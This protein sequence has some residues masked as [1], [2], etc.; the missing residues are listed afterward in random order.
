M[1]PVRKLLSTCVPDHLQT[2]SRVRVQAQSIRYKYRIRNTQRQL[3]QIQNQKRLIST[4]LS[5]HLTQTSFGKP[6]E[7]ASDKFC[8]SG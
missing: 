5:N 8:R 3:Q 2:D 7:T 6:G 1:A 4:I